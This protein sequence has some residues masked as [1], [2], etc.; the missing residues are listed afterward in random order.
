MATPSFKPEAHFA[1]AKGRAWGERSASWREGG[2]PGRRIPPPG[3]SVPGRRKHHRPWRAG[4]AGCGCDRQYASTPP[5]RIP[6][7]ICKSG[8]VSYASERPGRPVTKPGPPPSPVV[9]CSRAAPRAAVTGP[10]VV[11][12][13]AVGGGH[14][15]A[16][17]QGGP[18]TQMPAARRRGGV[19]NGRG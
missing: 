12:R 2:G 16:R 3:P 5:G 4:A 13:G 19:E 9:A 18:V 14:P 1:N 15:G 10:D 11:G 7:E 8:A 17:F 6:A